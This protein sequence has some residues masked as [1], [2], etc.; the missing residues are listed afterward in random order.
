MSNHADNPV[1]I[2]SS[3]GFELAEQRFRWEDVERITA[4]RR[5]GGDEDELALRFALRDGR[6]VEVPESIPGFTQLVVLLPELLSGFPESNE[7]LYEVG[8]ADP[9]D[10]ELLYEAAGPHVR[11]MSR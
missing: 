4:R 10:E 3:D 8:D 6:S 7:W 1:V 5:P 2:I 9:S 11:G